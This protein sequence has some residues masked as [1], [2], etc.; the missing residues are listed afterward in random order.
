MNI[1]DWYD[2]GIHA[3]IQINR[4]HTHTRART[5]M[6]TKRHLCIYYH[7]TCVADQFVGSLLKYET[8][9]MVHWICMRPCIRG[10][11]VSV[12]RCLPRLFADNNHSS[13][14]WRAVSVGRGNQLY[15][16]VWPRS[17][18]VS[19]VKLVEWGHSGP[20]AAITP[21]Q[22]TES[23]HSYTHNTSNV[24]HVTTVSLKNSLTKDRLIN[25]YLL[26]VNTKKLNN[27]FYHWNG[28]FY[29]ILHGGPNELFL[30]PV[31]PPRLV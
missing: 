16:K 24:C 9:P 13:L 1:R 25:Y 6:Y 28:I 27:A 2:E 26:Q 4:Q 7:P 30:V 29:T 18:C 20:P 12:W 14:R 10:D 17:W 19:V 8:K 11:D 5:H 31:S 21:W 15:Q 22:T 23:S 3:C